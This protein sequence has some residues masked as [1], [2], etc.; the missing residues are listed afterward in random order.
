MKQ[1]SRPKLNY[2]G[3][4]N[5]SCFH[6]CEQLRLAGIHEICYEYR[7]KS[8]RTVHYCLKLDDTVF[9]TLV[10]T[11]Q[12]RFYY[13]NSDGE[14]KTFSRIIDVVHE[15]NTFFSDQREQILYLYSF[16]FFINQKQKNK[17]KE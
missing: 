3:Y 10:R 14:I 16:E 5:Y 6:V 9:V 13:L 15:V 4:S 2:C 7:T 12:N 11:S 8:M 17:F 1:R